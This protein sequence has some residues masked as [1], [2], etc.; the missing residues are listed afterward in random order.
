MDSE[1]YRVKLA[2]GRNQS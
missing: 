1:F 2:S